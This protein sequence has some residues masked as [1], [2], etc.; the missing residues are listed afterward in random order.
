[1]T[2]RNVVL[3][4][5]IGTLVVFLSRQINAFACTGITLKGSDGTV[6]YGRTVEWGP[7]D[8]KPRL[9]IIPAGKKFESKMPD[10]T[11][12]KTWTGTYGV[13]GTDSL[14]KD[15]I[16]DG[17][18]EAGL[19]VGLFYH[20]GF[21]SYADYD[22]AQA[23]NT[24]GPM[25]V[26]GFILSQCATVQEARKAISEIRVVPVVEPALGFPPPIHLIVTDQDGNSIV[27][28]YLNGEQTIFENPLG[29]ITNSPSFDWHMTNLRNYL[30]LS[31]LSLPEAN[32]GDLSFTP[33]GA[34]SGMIGL[35][36]D[37]TPPS[38]FVR[39]VAFS[40][41]ARTTQGGF[42]TVIELFRILDSFNV[43][44]GAAEGAQDAPQLDDLLYSAT[45]WTTASDQKNRVFYYHT[46]FNRRMRSVDLK[47]IDFDNIGAE[48]I[49]KPLDEK[50]E[51]DIEDVTPGA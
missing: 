35:P 34:G 15:Y 11:I 12:G 51:Q 25:D 27:I 47:R 17:M 32:I 49:Q 31:A 43:P 39:A 6:A 18:N 29:A 3:S 13:V 1:M 21:A 9:A 14:E 48:I 26:A 36:G 46:Q 2:V 42:D 23:A 45:Q 7:F 44:I 20:P 28:E 16:V 4:V 50:R 22:P 40:Q 33:L 10:G 38:R 8:L 24:L 19:T 5:V 30:N 37:F 41:T